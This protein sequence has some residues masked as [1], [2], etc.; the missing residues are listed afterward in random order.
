MPT[1]ETLTE[2]VPP[3]NSRAT[4]PEVFNWFAQHPD[5]M[6]LPV[7]DEGRPVGLIDRQD[8]L[9]KLASPLGQSRYASRPIALIMDSEPAV[10]DADVR[11]SAFSDSILKS[12]AATLM[13]GFIVTRHGAYYGVGTAIKLFHFVNGLQAERL[14]EQD[15]RIRELETRTADHKHI[16]QAKARFACTLTQALEAPLS[17]VSAMADLLA[18]QP[19]PAPLDTY[20]E[21]IR[22]SARDGAK[23]LQQARDLA[24]ADTG[25]YVLDPQPTVLRTFMDNIAAEWVDRAK[26]AGVTLMVSYDGDSELMAQL[27]ARRFRETYDTLIDCAL[28]WSRDGVVEAGLKAE[29]TDSGVRLAARV[30]D[31]GPGLDPD[32]LAS[33]FGDLATTGNLSATT[34]WHLLRALDGRIFAENN[35]GRGTTYGFDVTVELAVPTTEGE[36]NVTRLDSLEISVRPHIL[37]ADDNATNRV[38]ARALCEMFGCTAEIAEDGQEAF[39]AVRDGRFDMVLMDIKMPRMDGVQATRAI[40][41]LDDDR[42]QVPVIAL[43]ANAD[44]DD[45][46]GYIQAGMVCVVEKPI[47]PER[48]RLAIM[49]ALSPEFSVATEDRQSAIR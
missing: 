3:M 45:V 28:K 25:R 47:K 34:A 18:R 41:A 20:V 24:A 31:D 19:H 44:P 32:Q 48:L 2:C 15:A 6:A 35:S 38:V 46:E 9:L 21:A 14:Q 23:L 30:R 40:R 36:A 8:F 1:I 16:A 42:A 4:V 11:I 43:T 10:V 22:Q 27:D 49:R 13:R 29:R 5:T 7:V 12:S 33:C 37:I 26:A 17:A 39:E